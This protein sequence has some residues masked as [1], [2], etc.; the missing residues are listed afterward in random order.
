MADYLLGLD[1]GTGGAKACIIDTQGEVRGYAFE[2]YPFYHDKPGWS[3]HDAAL[4]WT[5]GCRLIQQCL[6]QA[7]TGPATSSVGDG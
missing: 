4:Y 1:Y 5:V 2:E 6:A 3:E 7:D